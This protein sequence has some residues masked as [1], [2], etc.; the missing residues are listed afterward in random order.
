M[1]ELGRRARLSSGTMSKVS[2]QRIL[3]SWDFCYRIATPLQLP[4]EQ[5]FRIAGLLPPQS[6]PVQEEAEIL[7][8]VRKLTGAARHTVLTMLRAV[9]G[10]AAASPLDRLTDLELELLDEFRR[11]SPE[12]QQI[13]VEEVQRVERLEIRIIGADNEETKEPASPAI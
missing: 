10:Q 1:N 3:P 9:G 4:P 6:P 2:T 12:W 11:L 7:D 8:I 5:L 13:A